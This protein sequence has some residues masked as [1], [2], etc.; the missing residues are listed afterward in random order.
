MPSVSQSR[1]IVKYTGETNYD[2][3]AVRNYYLMKDKI[4][5]FITMSPGLGKGWH[6]KFKSDTHKDYITVNYHK[7]KVPKYYDKLLEKENPEL[8]EKIKVKRIEKAKEIQKDE[9]PQ[10]RKSKDTILKKRLS[11]IQRTLK[12]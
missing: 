12:S 7:S 2:P 3:I 8:L 1:S 5:E 9:T 6:E 10:M 4:P 11:T